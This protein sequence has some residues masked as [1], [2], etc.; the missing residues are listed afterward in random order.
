M[1]D[2]VSKISE[3]Y[4]DHIKDKNENEL[5]QLI[6][7]FT[8]YASV[9]AELPFFSEHEEY[10]YSDTMKR[11]L[12]ITHVLQLSTFI[13]I[14]LF[15]ELMKKEGKLSEIEYN[16]S[17]LLIEKYIV[18]RAL[19]GL[20]TSGYNKIVFN[21]IAELSCSNDIYQSLDK[22]LLSIKTENYFPKPEEIQNLSLENFD[23][24][25]AKLILFWIELKRRQEGSKYSDS[26][27]PLQYHFQLIQHTLHLLYDLHNVMLLPLYLQF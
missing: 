18:R 3:N 13:P 21:L 17:L 11:F 1:S 15:F 12:Q 2:S 9:F 24:K 4:K 23:T 25:L 27:E 8:K 26:R 10:S 14:A 7:K 16:N 19:L 5:I 22:F 20:T 6:E